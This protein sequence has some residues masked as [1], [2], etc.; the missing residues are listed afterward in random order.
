M[1]LKALTLSLLASA[2]LTT[3]SFAQESL[4]EQIKKRSGQIA[5]VKALLNDADPNTRAAALDIM[6]KSKDTAM[7]E[8]A[9]ATGFNSADDVLRAVTL[10]NKFNETKILAVEAKLS[11]QPTDKNKEVFNKRLNG[12][13]LIVN[14]SRYEETTGGFTFSTRNYNSKRT[15]S[16]TGL[17]L[18]FDGSYC[19]GSYSLSDTSE[20]EGTLSCEGQV[21]PSKIQLN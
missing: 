7:R 15:G 11:E 6:L 20:L 8:L 17:K 10:R 12:G 16:L 14:I 21:F 2:I 5:E 3:T 13:V 9:Y 18:N 1:K 4:V 19:T